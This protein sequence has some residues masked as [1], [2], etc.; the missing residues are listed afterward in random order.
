MQIDEQ[1]KESQVDKVLEY[2]SVSAGEDV[3]APLAA[4]I[5]Q[6]KQTVDI[7]TRMRCEE[8]TWA[9]RERDIT[10]KGVIPSWTPQIDQKFKAD[11]VQNYTTAMNAFSDKAA[12]TLPRYYE[13]IIQHL[14]ES[15]RLEADNLETVLINTPNLDLPTH[16]ISGEA[17]DPEEAKRARLLTFANAHDIIKATSESLAANIG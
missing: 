13:Y 8:E 1:V 15:F 4:A 14:I 2:V 5:E 9:L 7:T 3:G 12:S 6:A 16:L 17:P 11:I 10:P